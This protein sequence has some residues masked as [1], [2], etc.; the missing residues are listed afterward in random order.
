MLALIKSYGV[1]GI[2]GFPVTAEVDMHAGMLLPTSKRKVV[3]TTCPL[4]LVCLQQANKF[5][6]KI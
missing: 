5:L 1:K 6:T 4:P 2:E 3:C